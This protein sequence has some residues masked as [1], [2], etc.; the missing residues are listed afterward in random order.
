MPPPRFDKPAHRTIELV[1]WVFL[2][3]GGA[4]RSI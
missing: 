1:G 2:A 4:K 3:V